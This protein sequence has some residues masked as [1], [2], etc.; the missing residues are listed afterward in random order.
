MLCR[1][2]TVAS[3]GWD[4]HG[5]GNLF[6]AATLCPLTGC[7]SLG[8]KTTYVQS[9]PE[10]EAR[11]KGLE[12]RVSALEQAMT[13]RQTPTLQYG[14]GAEA[15]VSQAPSAADDPDDIEQTSAARR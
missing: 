3:S 1:F 7:F 11:V 2:V 10:L 5:D 13:I 12:T 6:C 4:M 15:I 8:G 9:S 14:S